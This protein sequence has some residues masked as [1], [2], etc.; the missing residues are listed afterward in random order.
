MIYDFAL[1][2]AAV[3]SWS[4]RTDFGYFI[5]KF[6]L[7]E[8]RRFACYP[9]RYKVWKQAVME[10]ARKQGVSGKG[11]ARLAEL[12]KL[13]NKSSVKIVRNDAEYDESLNWFENTSQIKERPVTFH[14]LI[15]HK[16]AS[17]QNNVIASDQSS[18]S[19]HPL[20]K[21]PRA[22]R[23]NRTANNLSDAV[24]SLLRFSSKIVFVDPHFGPKKRYWKSFEKLF[25][26]IMKNRVS[27]N[28]PLV[29]IHSEDKGW[30]QGQ[31]IIDCK[32]R[33]GPLIPEGL[34]VRFVRLTETVNED[35]L[36]DRF[37]LTNLGGV[38]VSVGLD[39]NTHNPSAKTKISL[40][41]S[42][43]FQE[44][45]DDYVLNPVFKMAYEFELSKT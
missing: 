12:L 22:V 30:T 24:H 45:W 38:D 10:A 21:K 8:P 26:A 14:A 28:P 3:A 7:G 35:E 37:I 44:Y 2:P 32:L 9:G 17:D 36:H 39:I 34:K 1:E 23:V 13:F 31:F 42:G 41:E 33:F 16:P 6:S 15:L 43:V 4:E 18:C 27:I 20:W 40:L 29:E 25:E 19:L 5:E 11:K